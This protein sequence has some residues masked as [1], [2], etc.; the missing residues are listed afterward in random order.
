MTRLSRLAW[1]TLAV[2]VVVILWG[3][4]VRAT[5]SGAGCGEHWPLCNGVVLQRNATVE[6][7]IE[8]THRLTSGLA[9][10][11]VLAVA[12]GAWRLRP[13][14][15]FVRRAAALSLAIILLEAALGAGLVLFRLVA[16]NDSMARA[17]FMG[18]HLV[19]TFFLLATLTVTAYAASGGEAPDP[20][21]A[22]GLA[23][24]FAAVMAGLAIAGASGAV[25]ALGDTL[26]PAGTL[27]EALVQDLSPTAHLLVRLRVFH[28]ALAIGSGLL[29]AALARHTGRVRPAPAVSR[30]AAAVVGLV[31]LQIL[32][33]F[34]NVMLLAPVWL[35][36][37]HLLL[38]DTLWILVVLLAAHALARPHAVVADHRLSAAHAR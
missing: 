34:V 35:Q 23:A 19:N 8:F 11:L 31:V 3:A 10:I 30:L 6:T 36:L 20:G 25:A 37:V 26:F 22:P 28:P 9:L 2:N 21:G 29:A 17:L 14:Q 1:I 24:S 16:D 4:F 15:P 18:V 38:A 32:A 5:G 12:V 33:G 13:R 7:L 27:Q